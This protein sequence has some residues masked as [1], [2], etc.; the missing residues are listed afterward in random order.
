M[1]NHPPVFK[2]NNLVL[3]I[4]EWCQ[5]QVMTTGMGDIIGLNG[6]FVL[7]M[8]KLHGEEGNLSLFQRI[9]HYANS[10]FAEERRIRGDKKHPGDR[11][12]HPRKK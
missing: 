3:E 7:E 10:L 4:F 9:M 5:S 12:Q 2:K 8:M 6:M 11:V 1:Y